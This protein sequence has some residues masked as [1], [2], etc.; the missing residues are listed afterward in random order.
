MQ[1]AGAFSVI[2]KTDGLFAARYVQT[3]WLGSAPAPAAGENLHFYGFLIF[4]QSINIINNPGHGTVKARCML[5]AQIL[6]WRNRCMLCKQI[7][8]NSCCGTQ[9]TEGTTAGNYMNYNY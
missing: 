7:I 1:K 2:V 4:H 5:H 9:Y 6:G 8:D 3:V